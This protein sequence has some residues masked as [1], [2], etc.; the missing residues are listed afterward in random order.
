M[1][2]RLYSSNLTHLKETIRPKKVIVLGDFAE[3]YSFIVQDEMLGYYW[4]KSQCSVFPVVF[5]FHS[6]DVLENSFICILSDDLGH[7][8]SFVCMIHQ[9][10]ITYLHK[11]GSKFCYIQNSLLLKSLI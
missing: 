4:N 5:Y 7:Y 2:S 1:Y 10:T 3:N 6:N 11:E 8:V 9:E